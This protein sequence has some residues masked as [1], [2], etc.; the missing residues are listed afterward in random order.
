MR[1]IM[2]RLKKITT[3]TLAKFVFGRASINGWMDCCTGQYKK[4]ELVI[5]RL[6]SGDM[7][8]LTPLL[9]TITQVHLIGKPATKSSDISWNGFLLGKAPWK[10][11]GA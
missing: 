10:H 1:T 2:G 8:N 5:Q 7:L 9:L 11:G 6:L 4:P 3:V